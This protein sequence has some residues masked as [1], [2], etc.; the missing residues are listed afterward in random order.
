MST[1]LMDQDRSNLFNR[2]DSFFSVEQEQVTQ[3]QSAYPFGGSGYRKPTLSLSEGVG[4]LDSTDSPKYLTLARKRKMTRKRKKRK[5][6]TMGSL[7][8]ITGRIS[9]N[10]CS[11]VKTINENITVPPRC[12]MDTTTET[13]YEP[14][15]HTNKRVATSTTWAAAS[16]NEGNHCDRKQ[17]L[18]PKYLPYPPT[19][20]GGAESSKAAI[21]TRTHPYERASAAASTVKAPA[22]PPSKSIVSCLRTVAGRATRNSDRE[23]PI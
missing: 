15:Y 14:T 7:N 6:K 20:H 21:W 18:Y 9:I 12:L 5:K 10:W 8:W 3:S 2:S 4:C 16:N 1:S 22:P 23:T 13:K 19:R 11:P 17:V